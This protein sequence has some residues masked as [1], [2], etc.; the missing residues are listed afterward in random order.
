[1]F[2]AARRPFGEKLLASQRCKAPSRGEALSAAPETF[3]LWGP[4]GG[5]RP[6]EAARAGGASR[7]GPG[8][9]S[10]PGEAMGTF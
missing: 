4:H 9:G 2:P 1:M 10:P 3:F 6:G 7:V 8:G 5:G